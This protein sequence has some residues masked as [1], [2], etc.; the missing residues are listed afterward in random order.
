MKE[1]LYEL[2][3]KFGY[4]NLYDHITQT[5]KIKL[6][7]SFNEGELNHSFAF[8]ILSEEK[9]KDIF[10]E[11][12][13][14]HTELYNKLIDD[15]EIN[16]LNS[17]LVYCII[18]SYKNTKFSVDNVDEIQSNI[19]KYKNMFERYE[20]LDGIIDDFVKIDNVDEAVKKIRKYGVGT[21]NENIKSK[22][23]K[24][25][26]NDYDFFSENNGVDDGVI[27]DFYFGYLSDVIKY[28]L[29]RSAFL[30]EIY[31]LLYK[32]KT[33][34]KD[35][36]NLKKSLMNLYL[37]KPEKFEKK[38]VSEK[39]VSE[40]KVSEKKVSEKKVSEKKV[41]EKKVSVKDKD[42][43][44]DVS[45]DSDSED[46][47]TTKKKVVRKRAPIKKKSGDVG[48]KK[49]RAPKID[50][51]DFI[52]NNFD[53]YRKEMK[54]INAE[55]K[56]KEKYRAPL[57]DI[58]LSEIGKPRIVE[59]GKTQYKMVGNF[60][61]RRHELKEAGAHHVKTTNS[62]VFPKGKLK[63]IMEIFDIDKISKK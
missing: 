54:R 9:S 43:Y 47:S 44:S 33:K 49:K 61:L 50:L 45:S 18:L 26:K 56:K 27:Y 7:T 48:G 38:K 15:K 11:I 4:K 28:R 63:K 19:K 29:T 42:T 58:D 34:L 31:E 10:A 60:R 55:E 35:V 37:G 59:Y 14:N 62:W 23:I 21:Q 22:V 53:R 36:V 30:I 39:K 52:M 12:N 32:N 1:D 46:E 16:L 13:D 2:N 3:E 51:D 17:L 24:K 57:G 41:S 20:A 40:K 6:L 5:G 8:R 25:I